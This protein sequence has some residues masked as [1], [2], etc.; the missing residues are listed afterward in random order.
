MTAKNHSNTANGDGFN[1]EQEHKMP[2]NNKIANEM[3][4][5]KDEENEMR[6]HANFDLVFFFLVL[7]LILQRNDDELRNGILMSL[8]K[9]EAFFVRLP[10]C[11]PFFGPFQ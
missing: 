11:F 9:W 5:E 6:C 3:Y 8:Y 2:S 4:Y 7:G 10:M 1:I